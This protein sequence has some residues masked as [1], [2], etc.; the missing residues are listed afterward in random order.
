MRVLDLFSGIGGMSLGLERAGM[1]TTAFCEVADFPGRVLA[2]HW[3]EVPNLKDIRAIREP[4]TCDVIAGGFPCQAFSAAARGRNIASKDLWPE[5]ER[6][7]SLCAPKIVIGENVSERAISRAGD[8]LAGLGYTITT[9]RISGADCRAPH[10]RD[11]WWLVA[12]PYDAGEFHRALDAEVAELPSL[13]AGLWTAQTYSRA[14][15]VPNGLPTGL[16]QARLTAL[17]NAVIPQ[18]PEAIGRAVHV[19]QEAAAS[20]RFRDSFAAADTMLR[21][22]GVEAVT[23]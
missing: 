20:E 13:C 5:M 8:R 14:I 3:P 16:D 1:V 7:V 2:K 15:R 19:M 23:W 10:R 12:H 18:I 22:A 6:V 17:G 9:R 4:I 21:E 11:R